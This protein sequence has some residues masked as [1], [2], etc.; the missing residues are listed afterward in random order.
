MISESGKQVLASTSKLKVAHLVEIELA[1][2]SGAWSYLTDNYDNVTFG[3]KVYL[4]GRVKQ[5]GSVKITQGLTN[6]KLDITVAAEFQ[7]ELDKATTDESYEGKKI[8]VY[9]AV[10]DD[11]GDIQILD[12]QTGGP[13]ILFEGAITNIG[14]KDSI[15]SGSSTVTWSCAGSLQ[16]FEK[17]NGRLTDD[18]QHRALESSGEL[19]TL[20][21]GAGVKREEYKTD[22][23]FLHS[24]QTVAA[25]LSYLTTET[26]YYFKKKWH[27]LGGDL[28]TKEVEVTRELELSTS[29][30]SKYLP[31]VYGVRRVSGIPVFLDA[32]ADNPSVV[33]VVYAV[34]EGEIQSFLNVYVDG[35]SAICAP[36]GNTSADGVCMG[37]TARGDT[38]SFYK[39]AATAPEVDDNWKK[40]PIGRDKFIID[41]WDPTEEELNRPPQPPAPSINR[42]MGTSHGMVMTIAA[43][44]GP[45]KMTFYHGKSDQLPDPLLVNL[46]KNRKFFLQRQLKKPDGSSW[47][48]E[49]W[50]DASAGVS[51]AALLDTA[52]VVAEFTIG[53]DRS[54]IPEL[55]FVVDGRKV[56]AYSDPVTYTEGKSLN[57][58]WHILDYCTTP[59]FGG[60]LTIDDFD[61]P[62]LIYTASKLDEVD[63]SYDASFV[64]MW[65]YIGW[66]NREGPLSRIQC[67][68]HIDTSVSITKNVEELLSHFE[69]TLHPLSGKYYMSLETDDP[70]IANLTMEE[71]A[72][73]V[74]INNKANKDKWNSI[75][76]SLQDPALNWA[77]N[78]VSFFNSNYL[79]EDN[80]IRKQG[81]AVFSQFTNYYTARAWAEYLL[82]VSRFSKTLRM[83]TYYKYMYL[84][85]NDNITFTYPRYGYVEGSNKFRVIEVDIQS[86]GL[87][88]LVLE[89][90]DSSAFV[91]T[92]QNPAGQDDSLPEPRVAS[93]SNLEFINLPNLTYPISTP[94]GE[95]CA[96]LIWDPLDPVSVM[97]YEVETLGGVVQV[98]KTNTIVTPSG[99]KVFHLVTG[100]TPNETLEY[101]VCTVNTSGFK[102]AYSIVV[103]TANGGVFSYLPPITGLRVVNSDA[104]GNFT[105]K[106]VLLNWDEYSIQDVDGLQIE[107]VTSDLVTSIYS[108]TLAPEVTE[109]NFTYSLNKSRYAALNAG[110]LGAYRGLSF[111]VRAYSG[112][113]G[114]EFNSSEWRVI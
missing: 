79:E 74:T 54:T 78:Q 50:A 68:S 87:V 19:G 38:L 93:P 83:T 76:A 28:R 77:S 65:R 57:P 69:G 31:V 49:Y 27:G 51:G 15:L 114:G 21:P 9:K 102:S 75:Q 113:L 34:C 90:Y 36:G 20:V 82:N 23:G 58:V 97:R 45:I 1:G 22:T 94:P 85:P 101:K 103:G 42:S 62:S 80:N 107:V 44:D 5:V 60:E 108:T 12:S 86:D 84:K 111:R 52:Y 96:L 24:N 2:T 18:A 73:G 3:G 30:S 67:N 17:V 53:E 10:F 14:L 39:A 89:R 6:Y 29:L 81:R 8:R 25:S 55:E 95:I 40:S 13:L 33:Y 4:A 66:D 59:R 91:P 105:G 35:V 106:N 71:L 104:N 64:K 70:V 100:L 43:Q 7:E 88:G 112:V 92:T 56:R 72:G 110:A 99:E 61:I 37:N 47:G 109:F 98:P 26:E 32:N 11:S 16:D 63:N 41:R 48:P 46:A